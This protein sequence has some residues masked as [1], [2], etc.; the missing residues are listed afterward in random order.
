M[1]TKEHKDFL[2]WVRESGSINMYGVGK[3][4]EMEFGVDKHEARKILIEWM[5]S[6]DITSTVEKAVNKLTS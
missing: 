4:L 2:D 3:L 6:F 1:L 5:N